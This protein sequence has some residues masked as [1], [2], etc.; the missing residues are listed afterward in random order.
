M[1]GRTAGNA[2]SRLNIAICDDEAGGIE[3]A[4]TKVGSP[5]ECQSRGVAGRWVKL[6]AEGGMLTL[7]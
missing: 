3:D 6:E 4:W 7:A 5:C 2:L 1:R